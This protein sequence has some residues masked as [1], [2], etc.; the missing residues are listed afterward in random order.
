MDC[1][2]TYLAMQ[3]TVW[4]LVLVIVTEMSVDVLIE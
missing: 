4:L 3:E 2:C 1:S